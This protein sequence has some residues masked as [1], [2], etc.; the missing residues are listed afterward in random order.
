MSE[1]YKQESN[2]KG[3]EGQATLLFC[4]SQQ[5]LIKK[6]QLPWLNG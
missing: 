1:L 2:L 4:Y 5:S 6:N 3:K